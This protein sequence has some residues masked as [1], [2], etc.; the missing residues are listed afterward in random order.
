VYGNGKIYLEVNPTISSAD[1]GKGL[2]FNGSVTPF[3]NKTSLTASVVM[4]PGQTFALGGL[5]QSSVSAAAS[6]VP[7]VGEIPFLSA[8]F[9]TQND[10]LEEDELI[11]LV[12]P[13]LVDPLSCNQLP[14]RLPGQESRLP[15]DFEFFLETM[16]EAPRGQRKV[17]EG[18]KY[19]AAWKNDPTAGTYPCGTGNC[20][21][22]E[23]N[24]TSGLN[25]TCATPVGI[26]KVVST[27]TPQP[28]A[29]TPGAMVPPPMQVVV[30]PAMPAGSQPGV[31][32][33]VV[34]LPNPNPTPAPITLPVSN[35]VGGTGYEIQPS[36][37]PQEPAS[38][39]TATIL[40]G[41]RP[42]LPPLPVPR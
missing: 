13:H 21:T 32:S 33:V 28:T 12:T 15:D 19:Q 25:G 9:S 10:S 39:S 26:A 35:P 11:V 34:P 6:R 36:Q 27:A 29:T 24:C 2:T 18:K 14:N 20:G 16:L 31:S 37:L 42:S 41:A 23:L 7:V 17:F 40:P 1:F 22:S 38:L 30:P 4:E 3:I 8:F 5:L